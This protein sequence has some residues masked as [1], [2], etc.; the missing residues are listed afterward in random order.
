MR[1]RLIPKTNLAQQAYLVLQELLLEQGRFPPGGKISVEEL[2][3]EMGVSR[4]PVWAAVNRLAAEGILEVR[5]RDGV[6]FAG[7]DPGT[8]RELY[9]VREELE[10][11][12]A[13]L[14]ADRPDN[15]GDLADLRASLDRQRAAVDAGDADA[16]SREGADFHD[17]LAERCGNAVL[18]GTLHQL[19]ARIKAMCLVRNRTSGNLDRHVHEH[20]ELV[21]ALA[22]HDALA[23]DLAVRA[24]IRRIAAVQL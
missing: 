16:Y 22:R 11:M 13:R 15:G 8:L 14:A 20:G 18:A 1:A 19:L 5:P 12:A 9:A 7:Y 6:F 3:R 10:A 24:H 2:A 21:A 17:L 23:A 4:S